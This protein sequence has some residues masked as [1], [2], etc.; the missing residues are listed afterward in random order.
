MKFVPTTI[1][2]AYRIEPERLVDDRGFFAR[3]WCRREF[4]QHGLDAGLVQCSVSF[5]P[6]CGTLRGMHY[7]QAP[8]WEVKLVRCTRGAIFDVIVDLRPASPTHLAWEG[9]E[10]T[11]ENHT[12]LYIPKG[13]AHGFLTLVDDC[14]VFYQM[15]QFFEA[16]AAAGVRWNDPA[17]AIA[18]PREVVTISP[19]DANYPLWHAK[20]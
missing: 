12:A 1:A 20:A 15:S 7:Q 13:L 4:E 2:G 11:A 6:K 5:S 16:S 3:T 14:E 19:R 9:F 17:F 8:H 18:W 10:L